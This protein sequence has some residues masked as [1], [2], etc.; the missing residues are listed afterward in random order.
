MANSMELQRTNNRN[1]KKNRQ[2]LMEYEE[3]LNLDIE[4]LIASLKLSGEYLEEE[5]K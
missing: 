1:T 5:S 3:Q 2:N 4:Q